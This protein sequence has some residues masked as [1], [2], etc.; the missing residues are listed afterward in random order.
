MPP[1]KNRR[2]VLNGLVALGITLLT[3]CTTLT[4][5]TRYVDTSCEVFSPITYSSRDTVETRLQARQHNAKWDSLCKVAGP[6]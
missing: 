3:S 2:L 1:T 6:E 5:G 4:G